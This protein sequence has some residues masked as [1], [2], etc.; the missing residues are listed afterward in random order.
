MRAE[1]E[2]DF[3]SQAVIDRP[4]VPRRTELRKPKSRTMRLRAV[5]SSPYTDPRPRRCRCGQCASC[6]DN[7]RWERIFQEKFADPEY[8]NRPLSGNGSSLNWRSRT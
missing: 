6:I 1:P 8:Y 3:T 7:A 5:P 2:L 4:M